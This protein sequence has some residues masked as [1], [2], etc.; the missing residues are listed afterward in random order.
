MSPKEYYQI[1]GEKN[2]YYALIRPSKTGKPILYLGGERY[3]CVEIITGSYN[4]LDIHYKTG[5][6]LTENYPNSS[7]PDAVDML[8]AAISLLKS[9][10]PNDCDI[11]LADMSSKNGL[12]LAYVSIALYKKT[13][14]EKHFNAQMQNDVKKNEYKENLNLLKDSDFKVKNSHKFHKLF[15]ESFDISE[16]Y[17]I[18]E[19]FNNSSTIFEFFQKLKNVFKDQ[20]FELLKIKYTNSKDSWFNTVMESFL[21]FYDVRQENWIIPCNANNFSDNYQI[22]KLN[23]LPWPDPPQKIT[24]QIGG[25]GK[26][27]ISKRCYKNPMW[28]GWTTIN[29]DTLKEYKVEDQEYLLDLLNKFEEENYNGDY[30]E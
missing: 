5:C 24:K 8:K 20:F 19:N 27:L 14:Y 30:W 23:S 21:H 16:L 2:H 1:S 9:R 17:I 28:I 13:W 10:F 15:E 25:G 12:V 11:T 6:F 4:E 29:E 3:Y 7:I 22:T 18:L 26:D